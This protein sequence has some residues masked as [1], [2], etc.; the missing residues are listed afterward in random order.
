VVHTSKAF[1]HPYLIAIFLEHDIVELFCIFNCDFSWSTKV[2]DDVLPEKL[3][4]FHGDYVHDKLHL[5]LFGEVVH[6]YDGGGIITLSWG[7]WAYYVYAP[8]L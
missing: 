4:D 8:S 2:I 1:L 6:C 7:Q 5:N 3:L